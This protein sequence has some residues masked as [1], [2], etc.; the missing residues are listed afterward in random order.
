MAEFPEA[1]GG[2]SV[3]S[4]PAIL[5]SGDAW[6]RDASLILLR[7][8]LLDFFQ[9]KEVEAISSIGLEHVLV[10]TAAEPGV[11]LRHYLVKLK[12]SAEGTGPYVDLVEMGPSL[13]L[14]PRRV[15]H[16]SEG[17]MKDAM[18]RPKATSAAP[19]KVK[20]VE[21]GRLSGRQGRIHMPKQNLNEMAL[22]RPKALRKRGAD[23]AGGDA[24][25]PRKN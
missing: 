14:A 23:G 9:L 18:T 3:E 4:K 13:D 24:K 21:H 25:R 19:K 22:A 7:S 6:E 5:F 10:F 2:C 20:N 16:A 8:V 12:K 1:R 11:L 17:L 15:H